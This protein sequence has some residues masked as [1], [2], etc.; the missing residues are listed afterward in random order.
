[1]GDTDGWQFLALQEALMGRYSVRRELGRGGMGIV[2]QA[3]E[4]RLDRPVA[5][6]V[7]PPECVGQSALRE[8]FLR[9]ART[10]AKLSHPNIVPIFAVDEV[11]DLVFFAMG[12]IEGETLGQRV[13]ERGPLRPTEA[14]RMLR[15]VA[16]ALGHA[17][18]HGVVHRDVK[19]DNILIESG[20]GRAM[21]TDFGIAHIS[22]TKGLTGAAEI[23]GTADFMS[24]EQSSGDAVDGRSDLYSLGVVGYY[25]L[26]GAL[27]FHGATIAATLGKHL[28]QQAPVLVTVAPEVPRHLSQTIDRCLAKD[29]SVRFQTGEALAEA[30]TESLAV[31]QEMPGPMRVFV[32]QSRAAGSS[33][34]ALG[35]LVVTMLV[36]WTVV[37]LVEG[38]SDWADIA[39]GAVFVTALAATPVVMLARMARQLLQTGYGH[40]ELLMALRSDVDERRKQLAAEYGD[41]SLTARWAKGIALGSTAAILGSSATLPFLPPHL[42]G[43]VGGVFLAAFP[44]LIGSGL[45]AA[46][47][48][49]MR[50][51]TGARWLRFW[52][53]RI[54]RGIFKV[55]K[56]R[57][58]SVTA[59]GPAYGPT[60][61]AIGMAS[62]R[63]FE[64]LPKDLR[65]SF[66]ELPD[67]LRDLEQHGARIRARVE[68]LGA[69][70]TQIE[71]EQTPG[72]RDAA[73]TGLAN[74]RS[75]LRDDVLDARR[76]A[77]VRL[78]EVVQA[79]ETIRLE[80]LR[81]H[82]GG[83]SI[84]S[85]TAD[86][87]SAR[88]LSEDIERRLEGTREVG[89]LLGGA[90]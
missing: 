90:S 45:V 24:P 56:L 25:V 63:L 60:V 2:Y 8:R 9:E 38:F 72:E 7:L 48:H 37:F 14:G 47:S 12:Y 67:V 61:V 85:V 75:S 54:G 42:W 84:E 59:S 89:E 29:P 81:M 17:H 19:P 21:V 33:V 39:L 46:A 58:G 36:I 11:D 55:A 71:T 20:T 41:P 65:R 18:L 49:Q 27:P 23:L 40:A 80:L 76:A 88:Q 43:W 57:L 87:T 13:R 83:G 32:E 73:S 4:V 3:H 64:A 6:K 78:G 86:L 79:L 16:W 34:V 68:K 50:A 74:K 69:V 53:S 70:L 82:A 77:D 26:T 10:A 5:L 30:L 66:S 44:A 51:V 15:E 1:M 62:R 52:E 22:E 35:L 31:R 28:T